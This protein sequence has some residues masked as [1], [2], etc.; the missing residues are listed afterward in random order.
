[1]LYFERASGLDQEISPI[2]DFRRIKSDASELI[3]LN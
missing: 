1:M 3:K 2:R